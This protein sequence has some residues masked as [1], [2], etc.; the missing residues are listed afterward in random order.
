M[1]ELQRVDGEAFE[2][3]ECLREINADDYCIKEQ[4]GS[5]TTAGIW[6]QSYIRYH[7]ECYGESGNMKK[8]M[9]TND[10]HGYWTIANHPHVRKRVDA[11]IFPK[12]ISDWKERAEAKLSK[13]IYDM[14]VMEL[15]LEL[16]RRGYRTD[17]RKEDLVHS[18]RR[19]MNINQADVDRA[20]EHKAYYRFIFKFVC[21]E[22]KREAHELTI[23]YCSNK[24]RAY[25][26]YIPSCLKQLI[27]EFVGA[28][29]Y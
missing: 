27:Y 1:P 22:R 2:C 3:C 24:A 8:H 11:A 6:H 4:S 9:I 28:R 15:K 18:L 17:I 10:L 23:A 29:E 16:Q 21:E 7:I 5:Y 13:P 20:F 14:S 25:N 26:L 19:A 12:L